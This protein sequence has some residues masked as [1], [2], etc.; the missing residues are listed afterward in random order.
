[1]SVIDK[2]AT[3]L[4]EIR[5]KG[6]MHRN[7]TVVGVDKEAR[8]VDIA[9]SSEAEVP[10]WYGIEIL[11]HS[12]GAVDMSRMN[13]GAAVL[14]NHNWNDQRGVVESA[15]I[16]G[17]RKGR[18]TVRISRSQAGDELLN[19]LADGIKRHVSVGYSVQAIKLQETR[20]DG[21]DVYRIT[22]W[23]PY[24]N[25]FV[26][27]PADTSVGVGRSADPAEIAPEDTRTAAADTGT[28]IHAHSVERTKQTMNEKITRDVAG[29]L[30]RAK[31]DENGTIVEVL[32]L[33][34]RAGEAQTS[35]QRSGADGERRRTAAL[36]EMGKRFGEPE[37]AMQFV[38]DGKSS[39]EFQRALLDK[40]EQRAKT[41]L[42]EQAS[43]ADV[44]LSDKEVRRFS[45]LRV[46]RALA[47]PSDRKAQK[48]AAFEFEVSESARQKSGKDNDH[49]FIPTDVLRSPIHP[50]AGGQR[51]LNTN[52][53]GD[54]PGDTGG[55]VVATDLK[56]GS[57]IDIL[58]NKAIL[59]QLSSTLGGLVGNVDI[60]RQT[61]TTQGFWL[62]EDEDT[63]ESELELGQVS[64]RPKTVGAYSQI[65]RRLLMQSSLDVEAL[66][67]R[68]L[69]L[70]MGLAIDYA[71]YYGSGSDNQPLGIANVEGIHAVQFGTANAPTFPEL[72]NME[73][74]IAL[75]NADVDGMAYVANAAFRGY[76]KTTLK[77]PAGVDGTIVSQGGTIW[78]PGNT[79]NGYRTG[80]TNQVK[81]GD[82]F[83][84]NFQDL[85]CGMW[86]GL[87]LLVDPYSGSLAGRVR[88]VVFQDVDFVV[89]R[90]VS[91][92]YGTN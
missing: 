11:D 8:T 73:T 44:G 84:G 76:A 46:A 87:E 36:V 49:F 9:F 33:I 7:G 66:V 48:E 69:A 38:S 54:N 2:E 89:R 15:R 13:D 10:R 4:A 67:R 29:N 22:R 31:V 45:F 42:N 3:R 27:V 75:A 65:T 57:F 58:R 74:Q 12:P 77:F 30:V 92:T 53:Q 79:V 82:V 71:G 39:E 52:L 34:E 61:G 90:N 32:E 28:V 78:E 59:L 83:M 63:T 80:I 24:E 25:S 40:V 26:S 41:P 5:A 14:W 1:M 51:S 19:D 68:D 35:A 17:D 88:L 70:Q 91:F 37:L 85:L 23:Q 18:A 72:V 62:G 16:D 6:T 47:D 60:P 21:T 43:G 56:T 86:G 20:S 64:L 55:F 50:G 81:T